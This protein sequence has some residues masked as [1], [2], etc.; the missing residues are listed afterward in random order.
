VRAIGEASF[1][2]HT[3]PLRLLYG[4][5]LVAIVAAIA[6]AITLAVL[7]ESEVQPGQVSNTNAENSCGHESWPYVDVRCAEAAENTRRLRLIS[8]DRI[9][10]T[11][12]NTVA[13]AAVI[14]K[15]APLPVEQ[16]PI[17]PQPPATESNVVSL[18][19]AASVEADESTVRKKVIL[20]VSAKVRAQVRPRVRTR[21]AESRSAPVIGMVG[22]KSYTGAGGGFDAVH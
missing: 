8:T 18:P 10:K 12:V 13:A 5:T 3:A 1:M 7:P 2:P 6:A 20:D 14:P 19:S 11:I 15:P 4:W 22:G 9:G 17:S 16:N 21:N